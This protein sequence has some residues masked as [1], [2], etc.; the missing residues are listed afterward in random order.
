MKNALLPALLAVVISQA[1]VI[2]SLIITPFSKPPMPGGREYVDSPQ[3][4]PAPQNQQK[5]TKEPPENRWLAPDGLTS[6]FT[7]L[8]ILVGTGQILLFWRQLYFIRVGMIDTKEAAN[9]ARVSAKVAQ[10]TLTTTNRAWVAVPAIKLAKPLESG[11]PISVT[12][13]LINVGKEPALGLKW[14]L[15]PRLVAYINASEEQIA[16][17]EPDIMLK[18]LAPEI[19][20]GVVLWHGIDAKYWVPQEFRDTAEHRV[21]LE[22]A[23]AKTSSLII[24]AS[25]AYFTAGEVHRTWVRFFLRDVPGPTLN[26]NF[27]LLPSGSGAD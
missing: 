10:K 11:L 2:G 4:K 26:W 18:E 25:V 13:Q 15:K 5:T 1:V 22:G 14:Y 3:Q 6:V 12:L 9:A 8:L 17:I 27:N 7:G 16:F 20:N 21:I 24:D 23:L 19:E